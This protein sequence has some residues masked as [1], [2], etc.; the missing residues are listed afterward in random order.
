MH[1]QIPPPD[2][3]FMRPVVVELGGVGVEPALRDVGVMGAEWGQGEHEG[4]GGLV[5][6]GEGGA[7]VEVGVGEEGGEEGDGP[8]V[9]AEEEGAVVEAVRVGGDEEVDVGGGGWRGEED[10]EGDV[11]VEEDGVGVVPTVRDRSSTCVYD[12]GEIPSKW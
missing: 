7:G 4:H 1:E 9:D 12:E 5:A 8:G 11:R 3:E 10:G 2:L 6:V